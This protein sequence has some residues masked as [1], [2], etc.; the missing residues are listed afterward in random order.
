MVPFDID[1]R[2]DPMMPITKKKDD[3]RFLSLEKSN[4]TVGVRM[5]DFSK[6]VPAPENVNLSVN[7]SNVDLHSSWALRPVLV[8]ETKAADPMTRLVFSRGEIAG[9][10][11]KPDRSG[12]KQRGTGTGDAGV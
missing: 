5:I 2:F 8:L 7:G 9:K 1:D 3:L 11:R 4:E 12:A 6:G 10:P